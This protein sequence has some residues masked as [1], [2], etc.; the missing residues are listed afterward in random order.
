[1]FDRTHSSNAAWEIFLR[2]AA[3]G[4]ADDDDDATVRV[5]VDRSERIR[6][7]DVRGSAAFALFRR[8][9]RDGAAGAWVASATV[10]RARACGRA[11]GTRARAGEGRR[12][13]AEEGARATRVARDGTGSV[14]TT[15]KLVVE[16]ETA[17]RGSD[18]FFRFENERG[19]RRARAVTITLAFTAPPHTTHPLSSCLAR[20]LRASPAR[21]S[22]A[23]AARSPPR[24][25]RRSPPP[26]P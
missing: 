16:T 2:A 23:R 21:A 1:M 26:A 5:L 13:K 20:A 6:S 18:H 11:S 15:A 25:T 7:D 10:S 19:R 9:T 3:A 4:I 8:T 22:P 12:A 14:E 17:P 24:A